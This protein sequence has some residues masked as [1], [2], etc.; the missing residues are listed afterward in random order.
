[1][2]ADTPQLRFRH[3]ILAGAVRAT[4]S[5]PELAVAHATAAELLRARGA[6]PERIALQ[7]LHAAP[8]GDAQVVRELRQ[9]AVHAQQR[10]GAT[11]AVVLLERAL[12]EPPPAR[13]RGDLLTE[14]G[15]AELATASLSAAMEHLLEAHRCA[16]DPRARALAI[17]L[18]STS[19][20]AD[21]DERRQIVAMAE[22]ALPEV[23]PLDADLALRL[24]ALLALEGRVDDPPQL[25]GATAAEASFLG[26]LVFARMLPDAS[27]AEIADIAQRASRQLDALLEEGTTWL[28]LTGMTM[29]FVW[30]DRL[31]DAERITDRVI[32]HARR[33]GSITDFANAMTMR[34]TVRRRA[35]RLRDAE[36]DA[37]VALEAVLD[38][39][40]AFMRGIAPLTCTL[41]E[42]GRAEDAASAFDAAVRGEEI[43][44]SPPMLTVL[45]ARMWVRAARREHTAALADWEEALRRAL[46]GPSAAWI[47]DCAVAAECYAAVG[48][49]ESAATTAAQA[50]QLAA[51]WGTPGARGHALHVQAR[52]GRRDDAVD[53]LR[54]AVELLS[55][56]PARLHEARARV[57]LGAALRRAG[58]RV[59]SRAPLR[60]GYELAR[61]CGAEG[62]AEHARS[63]L[64]ASGIRL[65]RETASG[66]D[67]LTPSERRIA[68]LAAAG[69]SNPQI[70]QEL[71]LTVKTI[72]MH[73]T[74]SYRKL[75]IH[76]RADLA[77]AL[78]A[79][80]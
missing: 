50:Q 5:E 35:G 53:V 46:R 43:A 52:V 48:D 44:D 66:A 37:R 42:Q 70:A 45:L 29:G 11:T 34:A 15:R 30:T 51:A 72:E 6:G 26:H 22:S 21:R 25:A 47:E 56:S 65:Q 63:E 40:W 19:M 67:A 68:E 33:R 14:L 55:Q 59:D 75:D 36:A 64:R 2:L 7:L 28:G 13:L 62:L 16:T 79:E 78:P 10:G 27:A 38:P 17:T 23:E 58:H 80:A 41:V 76:R 73:L 4:L 57:S 24:R 77:Q 20:L 69:L 71:F 60:E 61:V 12:A 49:D 9:A 54:R 18:L 39:A 31:A 3:P 32:A 74:R 8:R 1:M